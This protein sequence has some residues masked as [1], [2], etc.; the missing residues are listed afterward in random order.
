MTIASCSARS[1]N[2]ELFRDYCQ[3]NEFHEDEL[4]FENVAFHLTRW[5]WGTDCARQ[6]RLIVRFRFVGRRESLQGVRVVLE[7]GGLVDGDADASRIVKG[8]LHVGRLLEHLF[9]KNF[10]VLV[11]R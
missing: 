11:A 1:A 6:F 2:G 9:Q 5:Q 3:S 10:Q 7:I 4:T 8:L